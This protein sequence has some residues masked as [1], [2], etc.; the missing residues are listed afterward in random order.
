MRAENKVMSPMFLAS[1]ENCSMGRRTKL[2]RQA[3]I[4][5]TNRDP[6]I[7]QGIR[8]KL[9]KSGYSNN[10]VVFLANGNG[11]GENEN[12]MGNVMPNQGGLK[13]G[14]MQGKQG[15]SSKLRIKWWT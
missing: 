15:L 4:D 13:G 6:P 12:I 7:P 10:Q 14:T 9:Q 8:E 11:C 3:L 1:E 2:M 5:V